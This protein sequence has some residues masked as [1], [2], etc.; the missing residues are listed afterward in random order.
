M[1]AN[2]RTLG[3]LFY[4]YMLWFC[5]QLHR[6]MIYFL[7]F[8][9]VLNDRLC[10]LALAYFLPASTLSA[11]HR[12]DCPSIFTNWK[13]TLKACCR[14]LLQLEVDSEVEMKFGMLIVGNTQNDICWAYLLL[15][16]NII[17]EGI[18]SSKISINCK[19]SGL[20][21]YIFNNVFLPF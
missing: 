12:I 14:Q 6:Y 1:S 17:K 3:G 16:Y 7:L 11:L 20:K 21:W 10:K 5:N 19:R 15:S 9:L 4:K 13:Y 8:P 2:T 18:F